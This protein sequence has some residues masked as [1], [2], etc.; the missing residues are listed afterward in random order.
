M[1]HDYR[2]AQGGHDHHASPGSA[3]RRADHGHGHGHGH[4]HHHHAHAPADFGATFALGAAINIVFVAAEV[5]AGLIGNSVALLADAG[6]NLGDVLALLVAWGAS[7]LS[8]RTPTARYTYGLRSTSMLAALFNAL[9]LLVV[10][11]GVAWEA[12]RRL[13]HP[14][15]SGGWLIMVVAAA[16][17]G[18]NGVSALLF[19]SGRRGDINIRAAFAHM[20]ADAVV[21]AGVVAAGGLMLLTGASWIDPL[22]SLAVAAVIVWGTWSLFRDSIAMVLAAAPRGIEPGEVRAYL[23]GLPGVSRI[24]DLHIWPMSTT[25]TALTCHLVTPGGAPGD[26][27]LGRACRELHDRFGIGHSTLQVEVDEAFACPLEPAHVV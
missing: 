22:A 21:S 7:T 5:A 19:A 2:H 15:P 12:L 27:F 16:G 17:V 20:V 11:G 9:V 6:H 26:A 14:Q 3:P 4:G 23:E 10:T 8:R 1:A 24:H 18:V 13:A 25:E